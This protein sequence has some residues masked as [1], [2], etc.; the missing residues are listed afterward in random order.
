MAETRTAAWGAQRIN[1]DPAWRTM[2]EETY[3]PDVTVSLV[4]RR[5]GV[6]PNQLFH[7][8][9]LAA[10]G[11]LTATSSRGRGRSSVEYRALQNQVRRVAAPVP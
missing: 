2:V 3:A 1:P 10:Q 4:A 7:W 5:H 6:Q 9:K 11:A 8:R